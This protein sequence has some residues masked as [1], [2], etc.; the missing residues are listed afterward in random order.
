[1]FGKPQ[2]SHDA[3]VT[4]HSPMNTGEIEVLR[5]IGLV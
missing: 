4:A 5:K 2:P 3:G 1:M